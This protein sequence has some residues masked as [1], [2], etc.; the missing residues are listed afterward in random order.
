MRCVQKKK[1][2][3]A[4]RDDAPSSKRSQMLQLGSLG[5]LSFSPSS[6]LNSRLRHLGIAASNDPG[7][8]R[9]KKTEESRMPSAPAHRGVRSTN[10]VHSGEGGFG[11]RAFPRSL[12]GGGEGGSSGGGLAAGFASSTSISWAPG[13]SF[14]TA[15]AGILAGPSSVAISVPSSGLGEAAVAVAAVSS[16]AGA[17]GGVAAGALAIAKMAPSLILISSWTLPCFSLAFSEGSFMHS[18]ISLLRTARASP[19]P[20]PPWPTDFGGSSNGLASG[21]LSP[22]ALPILTTGCA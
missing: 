19:P 10:L 1:R 11:A 2:T 14:D 7:P 12:R 8:P 5:R 20:P 16:V 17:A 4:P 6:S 18:W 22:R 9:P 3:R 13:G 21:S 15:G